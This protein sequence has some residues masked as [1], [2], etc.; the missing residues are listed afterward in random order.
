[1]AGSRE[2]HIKSKVKKLHIL[3][4]IPNPI[5]IIIAVECYVSKY[6][7]LYHEI[8]ESGNSGLLSRPKYL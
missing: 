3:L 1:M 6:G 4:W 8:S 5:A 2:L 7:G